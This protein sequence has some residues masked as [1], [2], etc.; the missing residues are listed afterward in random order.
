MIWLRQ[1]DF[2]N[3]ILKSF[4]ITQGS[5]FDY[6]YDKNNLK[7]LVLAIIEDRGK[8]IFKYVDYIQVVPRSNG[9]ATLL[10]SQ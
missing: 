6:I 5:V 1:K 2:L 3:G 7:I 9:F 8:E 10:L 4:E